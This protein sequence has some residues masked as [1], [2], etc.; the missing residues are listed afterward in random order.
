MLYPKFVNFCR[1]LCG[2][3]K[4]ID[5]LLS[6]HNQKLLLLLY[7]NTSVYIIN[8]G[9]LPFNT[10]KKQITVKHYGKQNIKTLAR[11]WGK[12]IILDLFLAKNNQYYQVIRSIGTRQL[13]FSTCLWASS[14]SSFIFK[15][16]LFVILIFS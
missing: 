1:N 2:I 9:K 15:S 3:L 7:Q 13:T 16:S 11:W 4:K 12:G 10:P 14:I 6:K 8:T 5:N